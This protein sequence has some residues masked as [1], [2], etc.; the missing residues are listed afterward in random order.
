MKVL[1]N[2]Y[3]LITINTNM[4]KYEKK[5]VFKKIYYNGGLVP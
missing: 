1:K 4:K 5:N 3:K 2:C